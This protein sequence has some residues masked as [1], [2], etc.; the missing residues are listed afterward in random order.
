MRV[1]VHSTLG[2]ALR[3]PLRI[4]PR[5]LLFSGGGVRVVSYLGALQ[6]LQEQNLLI[7][8]REFCGVSA[9]AL[10]ALMLALGYSQHVL[11]RFCFEYDFSELGC[12]EPDALLESMETFGVNSGENLRSLIRKVLH[13]KGFGPDTTF[14]EL[15]ASGTVKGIRIW[16]TDIQYIKLLEFS[17]EK[18]PTIPIQLALYAS[19]SLPMVFTPIKHPD[20]HTLLLDGGVLDNYPIGSFTEKEVEE[21]LGFVF[22]FKSFPV[23]VDDIMSFLSLL[24][25]GYYM[26]SY[27]STFQKHKCNTIVVPCQE[28]SS[29]KFEASKEDRLW[30]VSKGR[31]ATEDFLCRGSTSRLSR[32]ASVS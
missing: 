32:R 21:T 17:A 5:R 31:Q 25:S 9:G 24:T 12:I 11:E 13:H 6:V 20:T 14:G 16:A 27:Q 22:E 19:M 10:I 29:V 15:Q 3:L 1:K 2:M 23:Q 28:F 4:P 8:V 26:P 30:L 7:H 18:T